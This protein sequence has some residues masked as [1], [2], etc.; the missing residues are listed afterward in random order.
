MFRRQALG[1]HQ[2]VAGTD[3]NNADGLIRTRDEEGIEQ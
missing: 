1:W 2:A 3:P